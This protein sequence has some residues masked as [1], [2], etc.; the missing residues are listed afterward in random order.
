MINQSL[1][2]DRINYRLPNT[3]RPSKYSLELVTY[4]D[5]QHVKNFTFEGVVRIKFSLESAT[6]IITLHAENLEILNISFKIGHRGINKF[7]WEK[8]LST[9]F[10]K[11]SINDKIMPANYTLIIKY[12]GKLNDEGYGFYKSS[13]VN[14]KG[15]I[16]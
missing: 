8:D 10:L 3:T 7:H 12:Q 13:Y 2:N 16:K 9:S 6:Q 15:E 11:I 4:L 1:K 5:E 14:E